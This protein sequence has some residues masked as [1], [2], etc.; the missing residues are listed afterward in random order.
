VI[1]AFRLFVA[2]YLAAGIGS[3]LRHG[4]WRDGVGAVLEKAY[5]SLARLVLACVLAFV[6]GLV[7][8]VLLWPYN[9]WAIR[10]WKRTKKRE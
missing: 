4:T 2:L 5:P 6:V 3:V 9:E 10:E 7:G 8:D 1:F